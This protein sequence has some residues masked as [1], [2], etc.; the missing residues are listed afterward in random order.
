MRNGSNTTVDIKFNCWT[1]AIKIQFKKENASTEA[2]GV[3]LVVWHRFDPRSDPE[4][5]TGYLQT[6]QIWKRYQTGSLRE[7]L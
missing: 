3:C 7:T 1:K 6:L 5:I 2:C 4:N